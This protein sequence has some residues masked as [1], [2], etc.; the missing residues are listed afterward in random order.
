MSILEHIMGDSV[1][2]MTPETNTE[3][4][5]VSANSLNNE[6]VTP[7]ISAIGAYTAASVMVIEI[8]G[9]AISRVPMIAARNGSSPALI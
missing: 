9:S 2:A 5:S 7:P 4:A 3:P 8:T 1:R 6:P